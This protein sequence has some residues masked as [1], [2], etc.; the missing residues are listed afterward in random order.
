MSLF[1]LRTRD[2]WSVNWFDQRKGS[3]N[4][5]VYK[6]LGANVFSPVRL[7]LDC[8]FCFGSVGVNAVRA[9]VSGACPWLWVVASDWSLSHASGL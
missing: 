4:M 5:L 2:G 7:V 6:C 3:V 1:A 9:F 8:V